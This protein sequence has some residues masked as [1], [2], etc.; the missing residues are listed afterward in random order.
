MLFVVPD[1]MPVAVW[2]NVKWNSLFLHFKS[3]EVTFAF[4][5]MHSNDLVIILIYLFLP[6]DMLRFVPLP[7]PQMKNLSTWCLFNARLR[8]PRPP[9]RGPKTCSKRSVSRQ[10]WQFILCIWM[11][12]RVIGNHIFPK[13]Q[14]PNRTQEEKTSFSGVFLL[15]WLVLLAN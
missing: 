2:Y 14:V 11:P 1:Q 5:K 12:W 10:T 8:T 4:G 6:A 3:F 7:L 9:W 13:A 15:V